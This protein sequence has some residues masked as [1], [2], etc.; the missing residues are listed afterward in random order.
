M[1]NGDNATMHKTFIC[2]LSAFALFLAA[3]GGGG[4]DSGPARGASSLALFAGDTN[5]SGSLDGT[6]SAARL[7]G[8]SG[9][10]TDSAGNVYV[11]DTGNHTI[12]KITPAGLVSTLAGTAG[13]SGSVDAAGAAARFNTPRGVATDS[14]DNVYVADSGNNTI[15]KI[16]PAGVVSTLAGTAGSSGSTDAAGA[17]A[18]FSVPDG[19]ATDSAGNV[20][21]ADS[22]NHTI[23]KITAAGAASTLAGTAGSP[24]S[25]DA[26]GPLARFNFPRGVATDSANNVYVADTNNHTIRKITPAGVT[27]TLAG[28]AGSAGT[29]DGL[30]AAARFNA[31]NGVA[32]DSANNV[33]VAD[34]NNN[35]IRKVTS[36]GTVTSV[37][38]LA[39]TA[40]FTPGPLPGLLS[41]PFGVAISG[42]SLYLTQSTLVAL[43][44]NRP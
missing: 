10:A 16:T 27:S 17:A 25:T 6:G 1:C 12:R 42:T 39:Q 44:Q 19:V 20:Y 23:R 22:G 30:G 11:A 36:A 9:V 4:G 37:A 34:T 41:A 29:I 32:T 2:S 8:A 26:A 24:G 14:A 38:G 5:T 43:V 15:R 31:P 7:N 18:R 13:L 21:V 3:C 35:T 33:Y 40:G 28:T